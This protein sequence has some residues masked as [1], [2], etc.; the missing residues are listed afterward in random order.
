MHVLVLRFLWEN[1]IQFVSRNLIRTKEVRSVAGLN[2][3]E[4][5][6]CPLQSGMPDDLHT[7]IPILVYFSLAVIAYV[8]KKKCFDWILEN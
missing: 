5:R 3:L 8:C 6:I 7:K 2:R 4:G 1:L